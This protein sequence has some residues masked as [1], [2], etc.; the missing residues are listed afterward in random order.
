MVVTW[1]NQM[2]E[3]WL[4]YCHQTKWNEWC[5]RVCMWCQWTSINCYD[6]IWTKMHSAAITD[7]HLNNIL[8]INGHATQK[9]YKHRVNGGKIFLKRKRTHTH[10]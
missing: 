2:L 4:K 6:I 9:S 5:V 1:G 8:S 7:A 3:G 10:I